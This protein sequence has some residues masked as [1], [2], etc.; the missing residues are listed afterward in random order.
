MWN[1]DPCCAGSWACD[2]PSY[3]GSANRHGQPPMNSRLAA[4]SARLQQAAAFASTVVRLLP[5]S[6]LM[7]AAAGPERLS[8]LRLYGRCFK[9][10]TCNERNG[11][12]RHE[13]VQRRDAI[14]DSLW[15]AGALLKNIPKKHIKQGSI[16]LRPCQRRG[17]RRGPL[18]LGSSSQTPRSTFRKLTQ[19]QRSAR[20]GRWRQKRSAD[21][22]AG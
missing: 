21:H 18:P 20:R 8:S 15:P 5:R 9:L 12:R 22:R 13:S 10:G 6:I 14:F 2:E 7:P 11:C 16:L 19:V 1:L 3:N 4:P 17:Q